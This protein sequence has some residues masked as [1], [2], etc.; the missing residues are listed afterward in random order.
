MCLAWTRKFCISP[1]LWKDTRGLRAAE[2][3]TAVTNMMMR[4]AG[5]RKSPYQADL[6]P[7]D[8]CGTAGHLGRSAVGLDHDTKDAI[9]YIEPGRDEAGLEFP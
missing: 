9:A 2:R 1:W 4:I 8:G 7:D 5:C 6:P 3:A